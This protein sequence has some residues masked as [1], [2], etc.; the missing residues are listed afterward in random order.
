MNVLCIGNAIVDIL[1]EV[2]DKFL[3]DRGMEKGSMQ[4]ITKNQSDTLISILE[5]NKKSCGGSASNTATGLS[6]LGCEVS[7]IGKV[8]KDILGNYFKKDLNN[9]NIKKEF[10]STDDSLVTGRSIISIT[11]DKERTMNTYLGASSMLSDKDITIDMFKNIKGVFIEGYLW[12]LKSG[13]KII[14][15]IIKESKKNNGYVALSLSDNICVDIYREEIMKLIK[16]NS[17]TYL[18]GNKSELLALL[19]T[20]NKNV[21]LNKSLEL[22]DYINK[23]IITDGSN[24]SYVIEGKCINHVKAAL[25]KETID[26]T[27]AGDLYASGFLKGI[28]MNLNA[29][30]CAHLGNLCGSEIVKVIGAKP[31]KNLIN[32]I[33]N[34]Y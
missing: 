28:D 7:F 8:G 25:H 2:N 18:F 13:K 20:T 31:N 11:P 14:N 16:E 15:K 3:L 27:G 17:I 19:E 26:T 4:M 6:S 29:R 12:Y 9:Y 34:I 10:I 33:K 32:L 21:M 23:I 1:S 22:S 5:N 30:E 24:G